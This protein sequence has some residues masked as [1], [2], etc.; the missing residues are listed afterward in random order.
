MVTWWAH[1]ARCSAVCPAES[2]ASGDEHVPPAHGRC[3]AGR[4][5]VED[6]PALQRLQAGD[7]EPPVGGAGGDDHRARGQGAAVGQPQPVV[8]V[9]C[10]QAPGLAHIQEGGAEGPGLPP[11]L[12]R[13]LAAADALG[14]AGVVDRQS[15]ASPGRSGDPRRV[16]R[17]NYLGAPRPSRCSVTHVAIWAR[18]CTCSLRRMF[19]TCASAV[20][21]ATDRRLA[22]A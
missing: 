16:R 11:D 22:M 18:E 20:R 6:T 4:G 8:A 21:G 7:A 19:S 13:Q 3:L 5:A 14:E 10:R 9:V 15:A 2:P 12:L 1:L 17:A